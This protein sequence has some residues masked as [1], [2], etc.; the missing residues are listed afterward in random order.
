MT[1]AEE[2]LKKIREVRAQLQ[3]GL[4]SYA[5]AKEALAPTI[6]KMN[7]EAKKIADK[8]KRRFRPFTTIGL[9]R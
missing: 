1:Q 7:L 8:Y 4:I 6:S 5:E 3:I 9:L 2:N